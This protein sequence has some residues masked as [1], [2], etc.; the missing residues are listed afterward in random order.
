MDLKH[1]ILYDGGEVWISPESVCSVRSGKLDKLDGTC[2]VELVNG[3]RHHI[4]KPAAEVILKLKGRL[5][6]LSRSPIRH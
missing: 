1:F 3:A 5:A 2:F 4:S 6:S